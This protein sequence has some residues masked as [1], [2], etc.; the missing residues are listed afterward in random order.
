MK[1]GSSGR[2][3][4]HAQRQNKKSGAP[5]VDTSDDNGGS[6]MNFRTSPWKRPGMIKTEY[7]STPLARRLARAAAVSGT[8]DPP[9]CDPEAP[10]NDPRQQQENDT[11]R[12]NLPP[13]G[14][15]LV[16]K[17]SS[18]AKIQRPPRPFKVEEYNAYLAPPSSTP[19]S[20]RI[21]A[22][23]MQVQMEMPVE[24]N[25]NAMILGSMDED[26]GGLELEWGVQI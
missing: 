24:S 13:S 4:Q 17:R 14:V 6:S 2:R 16:K 22:A 5:R 12:P 18:L 15:R 20:R 9:D 21:G 3:A 26:Y 8:V 19:S 10:G 1:R 23:P 7:M 11:A 25:E